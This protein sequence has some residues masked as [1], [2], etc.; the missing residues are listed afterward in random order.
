MSFFA[1]ASSTQF[2]GAT[3][4]T[5]GPIHFSQPRGTAAFGSTPETRTARESPPAGL[6]E[7]LRSDAARQYVGR[8]V[9]L[10]SDFQVVGSAVSPG[11]LLRQHPDETS[12]MVVFVETPGVELAV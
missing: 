12:P 9:L 4:A 11:E 5:T 7:W 8:W 3:S 6:S 10:A 2:E 1:G